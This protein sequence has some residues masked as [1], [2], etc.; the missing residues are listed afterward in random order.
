MNPLPHGKLGNIV[1]CAVRPMLPQKRRKGTASFFSVTLLRKA[2]A[3][4]SFQPLMAWAVSLVFL[5]ETRR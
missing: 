5:K 2:I 4:W 1:P 3:R